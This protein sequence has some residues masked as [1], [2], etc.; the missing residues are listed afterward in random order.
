M[1]SHRSSAGRNRDL[2]IGWTWMT[3]IPGLRYSPANNRT[4]YGCRHGWGR[5]CHALRTILTVV[6]R[7]ADEVPRPWPDQ[8]PRLVG[9]R[10]VPMQRGILD[11][12]EEAAL[13]HDANP[14][15]QVED[16]D[17]PG[18]LSARVPVLTMPFRA[19]SWQ[20]WP[21]CSLA[22]VMDMVSF[23]LLLGY[24]PLLG[25][26]RCASRVWPSRAWQQQRS[27]DCLLHC[28]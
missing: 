11:H 17:R 7:H 2:P 5:A 8:L 6:L 13:D 1:I 28:K 21:L 3:F 26:Q 23:F 22:L 12:I 10:H 19:S 18:G 24:C 20:C 27:V 14:A 25:H 9:H 15:V 16:A 4:H